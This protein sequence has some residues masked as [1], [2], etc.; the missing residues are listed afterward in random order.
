[1]SK[2]TAD[3]SFVYADAD[4]NEIVTEKELLT[5]SKLGFTYEALR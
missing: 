3:E 4:G 1:M 5:A 2:A